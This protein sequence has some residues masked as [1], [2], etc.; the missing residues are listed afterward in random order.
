VQ[1]EYILT[2][3]RACYGKKNCAL[4]KV[5]LQ[6]IIDFP[7]ELEKFYTLDNIFLLDKYLRDSQKTQDK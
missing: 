1:A 4:P 5:L 7:E 3:I 6:A 2:D